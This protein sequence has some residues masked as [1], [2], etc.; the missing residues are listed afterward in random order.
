MRKKIFFLCLSTLGKSIKKFFFI[1][2]KLIKTKNKKISK[3]L[4]IN[5]HFNYKF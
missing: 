2:K 4:K 1:K 5:N 3:K